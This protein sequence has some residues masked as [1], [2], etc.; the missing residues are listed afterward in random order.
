MNTSLQQIEV[1][2]GTVIARKEAVASITDSVEG[3]EATL[4]ENS[5]PF[6]SLATQSSPEDTEEGNLSQR[7]IPVLLPVVRVTQFQLLFTEL[8]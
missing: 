4:T 5:S 7:A 6:V 2:Y 1:L 3:T 8:S